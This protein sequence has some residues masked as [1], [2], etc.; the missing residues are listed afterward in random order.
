MEIQYNA[1][2]S[3]F[4]MWGDQRI[5]LETS[6]IEEKFYL[7]KAATELRETPEVVTKALAELRELIKGTFVI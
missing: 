7:E 4:V 2:G 5:E 1:D 3:P 6:P